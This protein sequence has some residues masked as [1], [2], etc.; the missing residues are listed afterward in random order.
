M[1]VSQHDRD[2][3][4]WPRPFVRHVAPQTLVRVYLALPRF[5]RP[6][7]QC[8]QSLL[9]SQ[10][11]FTLAESQSDKAWLHYRS[12]CSFY[13]LLTSKIIFSELFRLRLT[14]RRRG[15][16]LFNQ[17]SWQLNHLIATQIWLTPLTINSKQGPCSGTW[18]QL[19]NFSSPHLLLKLIYSL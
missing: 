4:G 6:C 1:V 3:V 11:T 14:W 15:G 5:A 10:I 9:S 2:C 19:V 13:F 8:L 17:L 12:D 7:W 18:D 16:L